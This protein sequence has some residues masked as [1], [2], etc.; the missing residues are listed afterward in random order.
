M[1]AGGV[2]K[3]TQPGRI[4]PIQFVPT[5]A[6]RAVIIENQELIDQLLPVHLGNVVEREFGRMGDNHG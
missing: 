6:E 4:D 5:K 1:A 2:K 3:P